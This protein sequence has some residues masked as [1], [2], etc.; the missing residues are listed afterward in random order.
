MWWPGTQQLDTTSWAAKAA[1]LPQ[2]PSGPGTHISPTLGGEQS[3]AQQEVGLPLATK[4]PAED[5]WEGAKSMIR[6]AKIS[7]L[8]E[9]FRASGGHEHSSSEPKPTLHS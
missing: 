4:S 2:L 7:G 5:T 3:Q 1:N 9:H 6:K 8:V